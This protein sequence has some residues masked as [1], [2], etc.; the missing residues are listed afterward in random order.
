MTIG[1]SVI[2]ASSFY[3][4][5]KHSGSTTWRDNDCNEKK[6]CIE[7]NSLLLTPDSLLAP[8]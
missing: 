4:I 1:Q 7:L 5:P 2:G 6:K 8:T 3:L